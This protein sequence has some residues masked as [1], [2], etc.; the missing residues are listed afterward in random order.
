M[1]SFE[2]WSLPR[3]T[4]SSLNMLFNED[5]RTSNVLEISEKPMVRLQPAPV[6]EKQFTAL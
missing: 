4:Q 2:H 6:V 1:L 5:F 3:S